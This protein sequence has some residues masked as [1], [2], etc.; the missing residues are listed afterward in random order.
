V[1]WVVVGI[2][3]IEAAY[4]IL[5]GFSFFYLVQ[6]FGLGSGYLWYR[7]MWRRS[8]AGTMTDQVAGI[9]NSYYRWKRRRAARKFEVYMRKH[10]HDPKQYFD[11]Y[12]N[13]KPPDDRDK[14]DRGPGGWVN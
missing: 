6:L 13:F 3:G 5:S 4:F 14:K 7:F 9:R 8:I 12:G 2:G 10:E 1:L 11:E